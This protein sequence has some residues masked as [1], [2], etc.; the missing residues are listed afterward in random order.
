MLNEILIFIMYSL[1]EWGDSHLHQ[2][3]SEDS[4]DQSSSISEGREYE[5][6][7]AVE[8]KEEPND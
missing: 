6:L 7:N 3:G 2:H 1:Q 5:A 8:V 4:F